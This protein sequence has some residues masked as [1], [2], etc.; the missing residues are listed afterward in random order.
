MFDASSASW[1]LQVSTSAM[2][3][4]ADEA[5]RRARLTK[6]D[7]TLPGDLVHAHV[8]GL[9]QPS[10]PHG[11]EQ[12]QPCRS[13]LGLGDDHRL[14]DQPGQDV[15][16]GPGTHPRSRLHRGEN[17]KPGAKIASHDSSS[18]SS[19]SQEVE[20]PVE[21]PHGA[22]RWWSMWSE[23]CPRTRNRVV[24]AGD[25]LLGSHGRDKRGQLYREGSP[26]SARPSSATAGIPVVKPESGLSSAR[27]RRTAERRAPREI[28]S[29]RGR[30]RSSSAA[31]PGAGPRRRPE[32][33]PAGREDADVR[34]SLEDPLTQDGPG[35]Q[36]YSQLSRRSSPVRAAMDSHT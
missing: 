8:D 27:A 34:R 17:E 2:T 6:L 18:R 11:L 32:G 36:Q 23:R 12:A 24:Q 3:A 31:E 14:G 1:R 22:R 15:Q 10:G 4:R 28:V 33:H 20:A 29:E 5:A 16:G 30:C 19:S 25:D 9:S 21:R 35:P 26:S 13:G 7:V